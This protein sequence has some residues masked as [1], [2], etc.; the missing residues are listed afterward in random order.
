MVGITEISAMVAAAGVLVGVIYYIMDMRNQTR[1]R[2]TDLVMRLY[3][4]FSSTEFQDAW[5]R[6]RTEASDFTNIDDLYDVNKKVA[7]REVN[8]VCLFFEEIGILL[9]RKLLDTR[10]VEDLFGGAVERAWEKMKTAVTKLRQQ[11]N[12]PSIYYYF[13]CLYDEMKKREQQLQK[14]KA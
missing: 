3:D 1:I 12:D 7:L 8:Q 9:Q 14:S 10:M 5:A 11:F 6:V 4:R 13:E 2:Q